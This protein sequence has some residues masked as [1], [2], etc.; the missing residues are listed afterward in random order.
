LPYELGTQATF[1]R[2]RING[3]PLGDDVMDVMLTLA[4]NRPLADGVAPDL[5]RIQDDFPYYGDPYTKD[6]QVGVTPVPHPSR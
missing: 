5:N 2:N 6:E 1:E 4:C 3:R